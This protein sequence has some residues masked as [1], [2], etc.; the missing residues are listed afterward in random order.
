MAYSP[1][2]LVDKEPGISANN[3]LHADNDK[4]EVAF[5]LP[6]N[7]SQV[8]LR[9]TAQLIECSASNL[10]TL[11]LIVKLIASRADQNQALTVSAENAKMENRIFA[12]FQSRM[13]QLSNYA[14]TRTQ[15]AERLNRQMK[16]LTALGFLGYST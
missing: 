8:H 12:H 10:N 16:F 1:F 2:F 13:E 9:Q 4:N 5:H 6:N 15:L 3:S 14:Q 7:T 11:L